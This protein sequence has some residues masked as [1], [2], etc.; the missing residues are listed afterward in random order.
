MRI[1]RF[2]VQLPKQRNPVARLLSGSCYRSTTV[3]PKKG[4]GSY[5]RKGRDQRFDKNHDLALSDSTPPLPGCGIV[6]LGRS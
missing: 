1:K 6:S 3:L 2:T 4:A 5:V